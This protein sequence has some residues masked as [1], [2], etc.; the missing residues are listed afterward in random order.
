MVQS[1]LV[2]LV[3]REPSAVE[4]DDL[5]PALALRTD[6]ASSENTRTRTE[7]LAPDL[8]KVTEGGTVTLRSGTAKFN[9]TDL[10]SC[11]NC[12]LI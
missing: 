1:V 7:I 5:V 11:V 12:S 4:G 3:T 9:W 6:L 8:V 2:S 10:K